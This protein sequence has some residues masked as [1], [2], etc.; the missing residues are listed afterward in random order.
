[1]IDWSL[2]PK[3]IVAMDAHSDF[4]GG[5]FYFID[6]HGGIKRCFGDDW[7]VDVLLDVRPSAVLD[8]TNSLLDKIRSLERKIEGLEAKNEKT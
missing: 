6:P 8:V 7:E 3:E 4:S 2:I 5:N 1:M